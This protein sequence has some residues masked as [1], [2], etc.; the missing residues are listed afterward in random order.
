MGPRHLLKNRS[1]RSFVASMSHRFQLAIGLVLAFVLASP[2]ALAA[3]E[4][5]A[6]LSKQLQTN[7]NFLWVIVAA[8]LVFLMQAGFMCLESGMARAK[9]SIN[10]CVKNLADFLLAVAGFWCVGFGLMFGESAGG[11][12]GRTQFFVSVEDPWT[13]AFF[14]F[15]AVFVGTAATIN[16]GAVAERTRFSAYL[17][18]SFVISVFIYPVFGHWAWGSLLSGEGGGWLEGLGFHDFAGSTVVHSVGGW[19]ALA[20]IA[21]IGP[22][23]GKF[24]EQGNPRHI[25]P[26][27]LSMMYLGTFI[28][29]FG[30]FGFNCGS[31]LEA[32]A[33]IA[34]IAFNT[35][36]SAVFGG[37]AAAACCYIVGETKRFEPEYV[38]NGVLGGLVGITAGC[39]AVSAGGAVLIGLSSGA[40]SYGATLFIERVCKLDDVVGAV[41]V[42][43]FCG[44]WGTIATGIFMVDL[45]EGS[46]RLGVIGVQVLGVVVAFVWSFGIAYLVLGVTNTFTPLR[47]DE[48]DETLGLNVAEHGAS[49]SILD[50]GNA[51]HRATTAERIDVE[52]KVEEEFGTEVGDL[53]RSFNQLIDAVSDAQARSH[54]E[55]QKSAQALAEANVQRESARVEADKAKAMTNQLG[56]QRE[57]E[58]ERVRQ[59]LHR[60]EDMR[61]SVDEIINDVQSIVANTTSVSSRLDDAA[62]RSGEL[63]E[64]MTEGLDEVSDYAQRASEA[65]NGATDDT[66]RAAG[67]VVR[68]N[69]SAQQIAGVVDTIDGI[70]FQTRLLALNASV[71]A[72]HAGEAGRG[73]LVVADNVKQL[74]RESENQAGEIRDRIEGIHSDTVTTQS[75]IQ[76]A[77]ENSQN[78]TELNQALAAIVDARTQDAHVVRDV[79]VSV[80]TMSTEVKA[81]MVEA[82]KGARRLRE[83]VHEV[84]QQFQEL[85]EGSGSKAA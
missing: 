31:T 50:L 78:V 69:E 57:Q 9:N 38:A 8:A 76:A 37:I 16:S 1:G 68:L 48:E 67:L 7:L 71:E 66:N 55:Q 65:A 21:R 22:R 41:A 19:V 80:D 59:Y 70:S 39:D 35:M 45:P 44:A 73:F 15:Q 47:V 42:H 6:E 26:S 82:D 81:G 79:I 40:V 77:V 72:A 46:T 17:M 13:A 33:S 83:R 4:N 2:V 5:A 43:G 36:L 74:S 61:T 52:F 58:N 29:V 75:M 85:L 32:G 11:F 54:T 12:M 56:V 34:P 10:V 3:E 30:W 64:K 49:S 51:M 25:Q 24:D 23:L 84:V 60:L 14:V 27:S 20:G 62:H 28:L 18:I 53:A 63:V